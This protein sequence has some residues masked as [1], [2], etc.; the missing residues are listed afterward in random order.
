MEITGILH[1]VFETEQVNDRFKKRIF[2]LMYSPEMS[3]N[4]PIT[5]QLS[6]MNCDMTDGIKLGDSIVVEFNLTGR[7][8]TNREGKVF[9]FNTLVATNIFINTGEERV[10]ETPKEVEGEEEDDLPF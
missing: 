8:W 9:F 10:D 2:V 5:F 4:Y 7:E 1:K 6:Q 3:T